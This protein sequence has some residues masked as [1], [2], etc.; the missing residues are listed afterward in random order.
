MIP[1]SPAQLRPCINPLSNV[2]SPASLLLFLAAVAHEPRQ[3]G[4]PGTYT[5]YAEDDKMQQWKF[6]GSD[7]AKGMAVSGW[8]DCMALCSASATSISVMLVYE[9]L[10]NGT[11]RGHLS[12]ACRHLN[13][14]NMLLKVRCRL[15]RDTQPDRLM[16]AD[17][18]LVRLTC[19]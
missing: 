7:D 17:P 5:D 13:K 15:R 4:R 19:C 9:H 12:D 2:A 1:P 14:D 18:L 16:L 10:P 3:G 8:A 11:L 6:R